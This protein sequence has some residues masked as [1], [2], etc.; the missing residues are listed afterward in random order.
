MKNKRVLP[1]FLIVLLTSCSN[2]AQGVEGKIFCF[3]TYTSIN[4]FDGKKEDVTAVENILTKYDKLSDNYHPRDINN[5]YTINS[6]N[7]EV[8]ID[9]D[10]YKML[11]KAVEVSAEGATNYNPLCGSLAKKWK[12]ALEKKEVLA[13]DIITAELA[14][15]QTSNLTFLDNNTV[16][17][18]GEAE[19][20]L[21]GIAKGYTLDV[22]KTYL[23]EK[24]IKQ[25][26]V[27]GGSSSILLGEKNTKDGLYNVGLKEIKNAYLKAKNCFVSTSGI[28]EQFIEIDGVKYSH[29][30]NPVNGKANHDK[31]MVIV[32]SDTGYFGDALSTSMMMS[33]IE[34]IKNIETK[35]GVKAIVIKDKQITYQNDGIEVFYH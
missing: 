23:E 22:V 1:L 28:T 21:G 17:R 13:D 27:N 4:L 35:Y 7:D 16:K 10:L 9:A 18:S 26:L 6:T 32:I 30:I 33:S 5:V 24:N 34:V 29:I 19:I 11:Q 12:E 2:G 25:Y 20:D 31:D 8:S 15:I 3:D 14:K